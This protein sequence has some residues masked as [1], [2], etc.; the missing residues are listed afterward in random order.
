M[1]QYI[2]LLVTLLIIQGC[3]STVSQQKNSAGEKLNAEAQQPFRTFNIDNEKIKETDFIKF[4]L[5]KCKDY[6]DG[7]STIVTLG[8]VDTLILNKALEEALEQPTNNATDEIEEVMKMSKQVGIILFNSNEGV[9]AVQYQHG[10]NK[11]WD[12]EDKFEN[13]F[14]II[15]EPN[16]QGQYYSFIN[17]EST[18][19]S[20]TLKCKP[21]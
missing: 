5:W 12:W 21:D 6:Y 16:G 17:K 8:Q 11:R 18:S 10:I 2:F 1:R 20:A 3:N 13:N 4:N 15:L 9:W 19:P 14:S 7:G